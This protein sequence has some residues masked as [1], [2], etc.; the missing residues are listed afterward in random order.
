MAF[1]KRRLPQLAA[2]LF[3]VIFLILAA[4]GPA[5]ASDGAGLTVG[6]KSGVRPGETVTV[7]VTVPEN[8]NAAAVEF[9]LYYDSEQL[10]LTGVSAGTAL[11]GITGG[12]AAIFS[13]LDEQE[14]EPDGKICFQWDSTKSVIS[15]AGSV[16]DVCFE[17][18]KD[19]SGRIPITLE[20]VYLYDS[21]MSEMSAVCVNGEISVLSGI[22]ITIYNSTG[23]V[24]PAV[25]TEPDGG[26]VEGENTFSVACTHACVVLVSNDGDS[27][28]TRLTA[29]KNGGVYDFTAEDVTENTIIRVIRKGDIGGDGAISTKEIS[30]L[31]LAQARLMTL[32]GLK[33][34]IADLNGDGVISLKEISQIRLAV[35]GLYSIAW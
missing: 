4:C 33:T 21:D 11:S 8:L 35:A 15:A 30:Q 7:S 16:L 27:S 31:R 18:K 6:S 34:A 10:A 28:Y 29:V 12:Q 22:E 13:P 19:A 14:P 25:I 24:S 2:V 17:V 9:W 20:D 26:W 3:M 5:A 1:C 32:D 23:T